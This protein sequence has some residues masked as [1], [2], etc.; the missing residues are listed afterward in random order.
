MK[1]KDKFFLNTFCICAFSSLLLYDACTVFPC[2]RVL[3][4]SA[5]HLHKLDFSNNSQVV[6]TSDVSSSMHSD[7]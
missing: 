4:S 6:V 1:L 7:V 5:H 2:V 3:F